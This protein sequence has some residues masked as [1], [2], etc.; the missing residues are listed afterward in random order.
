MNIVF[1]AFK[2]IHY[3]MCAGLILIIL[4]QTAKSGGMSGIFGGSGSD[5]IF[6]A[7][8]RMAFVKKLTVFMSCI[9]MFTSLIL[10]KFSPAVSVVN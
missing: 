7:P 8:S 3:A 9:F 5:Q 10:T 2:V 1:Y 6:D 4:L